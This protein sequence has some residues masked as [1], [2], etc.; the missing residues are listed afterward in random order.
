MDRTNGSSGRPVPRR[1]LPV[2]IGAALLLSLLGG[3]GS[4]NTLGPGTTAAA[5]KVI[6]SSA[7]TDHTGVT[8]TSVVVA[9]VSTLVAGL[10]KGAAVGTEAY[11][12]YVNSQGG[13]HGRR[14]VVQQ[15]DDQFQGAMNK[16]LT[17]AAL[18]KAFALVG[19]VSLEDGFGGAVLAAN[20]QLPNV[21]EA[22]DPATGQL[23]NTFS[24]LPVGKGWPLGPLAY[25]KDRF[26]AKVA[27]TGT[28][29]ADLPSTETAWNQEKAAVEHLGYRVLYD[30]ALPPSQTDFTQQVVA[31]KNAGVEILFL[32]QEPENYAS[33]IF[34][35]L[36]Q[37][38]FH[39]VVVLGAPAYNELLAAN[40]GGPAVVDGAYLEQSASLYLGEDAHLIG[41]VS[42]FNT[43]VH[44]VAPGFTPDY[45]TLLGWLCGELFTQ[46]LR[47]AGPDPSRG[48]LLRALS[49]ITGFSSGRLIP[50]TDPAGKVPASCYLL[51]QITGGRFQ[52][53]DDPPVDGPTDGY[54]CDQPYYV[55]PA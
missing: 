2:G 26:P 21:S 27:H 28:I 7:F 53:L 16:Q 11:A 48:S 54:R 17:N 20:P 39:P 1:W 13:V 38:D 22:L 41:A 25:F 9:N 45:F 52:R 15:S 42:V 47:N 36:S 35:D 31:M 51:G 55:P 10:F 8:A 49:H 12:A 43:W 19:G 24:P 4:T 40:S 37:Q 5:K 6:P 33:A 18:T 14:I 32:E 34:K 30:P 50:V 29:V 46:A 23:P 3:C 44:S